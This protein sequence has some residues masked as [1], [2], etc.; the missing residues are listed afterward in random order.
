M[1]QDDP[2]NNEPQHLMRGSSS[3]NSN[4]SP[5]PSDSYSGQIASN[6]PAT[7]APKVLS[8]RPNSPKI[9][10]GSPNSPRTS[11]S[12]TTS[13]GASAMTQQRAA[14]IIEARSPKADRSSNYKER[15]AKRNLVEDFDNDDDDNSNNSNNNQPQQPR[16]DR[17]AVERPL[18]GARRRQED[19]Q[20]QIQLELVKLKQE[21]KEQKE[22]E[23]K[24][25]EEIERKQREKE[26]SQQDQNYWPGWDDSHISELPFD[27]EESDD[28]AEAVEDEESEEDYETEE[29]DD[30]S[31]AP[32]S[33]E[34]YWPNWN[35]CHVD[36]IPF[37]EEARGRQWEDTHDDD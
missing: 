5:P 10:R 11:I 20:K 17:D 14:A 30:L 26:K 27:E 21:Q 3:S 25:Q 15:D 22:L 1:H 31:I 34:D 24:Q 2:R 18:S 35:D 36:E 33:H 4:G 29:N 13:L 6:L 32:T 7:L 37:Y 19:L 8:P 12:R 23:R 16:F 9:D 28:T